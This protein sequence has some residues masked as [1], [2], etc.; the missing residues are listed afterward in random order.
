MYILRSKMLVPNG[1]SRFLK[2]L[3]TSGKSP[4]SLRTYKW[5][6]S[7]FASFLG[8]HRE[9]ADVGLDDVTDFLTQWK[10]TK[11][12]PAT[13]NRMKSSISAFFSYLFEAGHIP[14]LPFRSLEH[15][16]IVRRQPQPINEEERHALYAEAT[17]RADVWLLVQLYLGKGLRLTE[18]LRLNVTDVQSQP[19]LRIIGKGKKVRFLDITTEL[20]K[21]IDRWLPVRL[22]RLH[23][24]LLR[25]PGQRRRE[26]AVDREA[27]FLTQRG[28]RLSPRGAEYL[29]MECFKKSGLER[30][31]VH[32]LRHGFGKQLMSLGIDLRTIQEILGHSHPT[33]TQIYTQVTREDVKAALNR[34]AKDSPSLL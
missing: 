14:K 31:T 29:I 6:V 10:R 8:G 16:K 18:A 9:L 33:T 24:V 4:L 19:T 28:W 1:L 11:K 32:K 21:A 25:K 2:H 17:R 27:L 15:E 13:M 22:E 7:K 3:N 23:K 20:K 26:T 5:D 34:A 12:A 30:L